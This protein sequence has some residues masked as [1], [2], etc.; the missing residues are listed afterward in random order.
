M[1][2][3]TASLNLAQPRQSRR[4]VPAG[5]AMG[6]SPQAERVSSVSRGILVGWSLHA[7]RPPEAAISALARS[8]L[9][10]LRSLRLVGAVVVGHGAVYDGS[11]VVRDYLRGG[12]CRNP[13]Q[14]N[15]GG[16]DESDETHR[17][18]PFG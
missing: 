6:D 4:W 14:R 18:P 1:P 8:L 11:L 16:Q 5:F 2:A 7:A 13:R 17:G 9:A 15:P 10:C 12:V 3:Q